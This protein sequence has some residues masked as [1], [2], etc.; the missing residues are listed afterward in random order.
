MKIVFLDAIVLV[1]HICYSF[2]LE[3]QI[4][5]SSKW[6]RLWDP[7]VGHPEDQMIGRA[8]DVPEPSVIHV[9]LNSTQKHIKPTLTGYSR[10]YIEL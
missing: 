7:V 10:L 8:G 1:L 6:G 5:K 4:C 3:K 9:F 2:L